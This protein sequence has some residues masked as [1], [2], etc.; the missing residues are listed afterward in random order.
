MGTFSMQGSRAGPTIYKGALQFY[1][2][3]WAEKGKMVARESLRP[4]DVERVEQ[5]YADGLPL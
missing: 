3:A 1:G 5:S 4:W 2:K